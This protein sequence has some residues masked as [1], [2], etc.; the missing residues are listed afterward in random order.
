MFQCLI[1]MRKGY[2][3]L[4][5][6]S[7]A[8]ITTYLCFQEELSGFIST[9]SISE[10]LRRRIEVRGSLGHQE[11]GNTHKT[12]ARPCTNGAARPS[13]PEK[14]H[15]RAGWH[16]RATVHGRAK[17]GDAGI[18]CFRDFFNGS[19]SFRTFSFL[20]SCFRVLERG[21]ERVLRT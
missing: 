3:S 16:D 17:G 15:S 5:W 9:D 13:W 2:I 8:Y 7:F 10:G 11:Q 6:C 1:E 12:G 14:W 19:F 4:L 21:F 18:S 20:S